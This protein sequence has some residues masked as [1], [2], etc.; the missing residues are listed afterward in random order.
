MLRAV[1][2][3]LGTTIARH[4]SDSATAIPTTMTVATTHRSLGVQRSRIAPW[5]RSAPYG[6]NAVDD[7]EALAQLEGASHDLG[8][9]DHTGPQIGSRSRSL[10]TLL[11][12]F[13]G[14][15]RR[16]VEFGI[17]EQIS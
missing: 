17:R 9:R 5:S 16:K 4:A 14:S 11:R 6:D 2:S 3:E 7:A 12:L 1:M 10:W 15:L 8:I 13:P